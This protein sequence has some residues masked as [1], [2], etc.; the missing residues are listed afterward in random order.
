MPV[1]PLRVSFPYERRPSGVLGSIRRPVAQ[2]ELYSNALRQW[3]GCTMVVDTGADYCVLPLRVA[4]TLGIDLRTCQRHVAAG[5]GG[6]QT[7]FLCRGVRLRLGPRAVSILAGIVERDD[8]PPLLGRYR[9][10]DVFDLRLCHFVTTF[11][12]PGR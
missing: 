4:L 10:L 2:V 9:C 8:L 6:Q 12:P 11:A 1:R 7:I 5:I 3:I